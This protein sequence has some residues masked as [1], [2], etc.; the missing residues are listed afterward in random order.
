MRA[1]FSVGVPAALSLLLYDLTNIIINKLSSGHGDIELAAMGIILKVERLPLNICVGICLAMMPLVAY[2]F[3]SGDRQRMLALFPRLPPRRAGRGG[4][5]H[6]A[7][8][9]PRAADHAHV[10]PRRADR[11]PRHGLSPGALLRADHDVPLLPYGTLYA[12]PR[13]GRR[14]AGPRRHPAAGH[15]H[16]AAPPPRSLLRHDRHHLDAGDRRRADSRD[17]LSHLR[18]VKRGLEVPDGTKTGSA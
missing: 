13:Q 14:L 7:L 5:V 6:R 1:I 4:G 8:L 9:A 11:R 16:P 2:N 10:H 18:A 17:L 15:E 12:G 3:A